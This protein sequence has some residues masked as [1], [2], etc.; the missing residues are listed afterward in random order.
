MEPMYRPVPTVLGRP[1]RDVGTHGPN[2][3]DGGDSGE[4]PK[5]FASICVAFPA[6]CRHFSPIICRSA[7][8]G[9]KTSDCF[10]WCFEISATAVLPPFPR[11]FGTIHQTKGTFS[12][13]KCPD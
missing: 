1:R 11:P 13:V 4:T 2:G 8:Q 12:M 5:D 3:R 10:A 6:Y 9:M 7:K